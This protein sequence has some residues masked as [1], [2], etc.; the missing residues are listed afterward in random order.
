[1]NLRE[2][3]AALVAFRQECSAR[4]SAIVDT[5]A[6]DETRSDSRLT[7]AEQAEWDQ[8]STWVTDARAEETDIEARLA[9]LD[10]AGAPG[11]R[12]ERGDTNRGPAI[13]RDRDP[14]A[15]DFRVGQPAAEVRAQAL[16]AIEAIRGCDDA[17]KESLTRFVELHDNKRA[18]GAMHVIATSSPEYRDAWR[19]ALLDDPAFLTDRQRTVLSEARAVTLTSGFAFPTTVDP[20]IL[21]IGSGSSNPFR[22]IATVRQTVTKENYVNTLANVSMSMD[23]EVEEVSD[24]TPADDDVQITVRNAQ[25]YVEFS[26]DSELDLPGLETDLRAALAKGKDNLEATQMAVGSGSG[27]NAQGIMI[28]ATNTVNSASSGAFAV[29]D[30]YALQNDLPHNYDQAAVWVANKKVYN[31]I[32][33]FDNNGGADL[34]VQLGA[35]TP[36]QLLGAPTYEASA[37]VSTISAGNEVLLY[38]DV[39]EGYR[40][41]DR[42]GMSVNRIELVMDTT[43]NRPNGKRGLYV[44]WRFGAGVVNANALRALTIAA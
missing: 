22:Q 18:E 20:T 10:A 17:V 16:T 21:H 5:A 12:V 3:L 35:G 30:L 36:N 25:G 28:G 2:R 14:F 37:I 9:V 27:N 7:P 24:D 29:A 38:G 13:Q 42:V 40:I 33:Q 1:M 39:R 43:N 31:L 41:Y 19:T 15:I 34:W 44:R 6:A 8:L 11:A 4:L 32:R 26:I 23:G